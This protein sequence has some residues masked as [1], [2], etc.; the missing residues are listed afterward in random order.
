[1]ADDA[2][3]L[4]QWVIR[5]RSGSE[6]L[7]RKTSVTNPILPFTASVALEIHFI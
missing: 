6:S 3:L 1:M 5:D 4:A 7:Q 2:W